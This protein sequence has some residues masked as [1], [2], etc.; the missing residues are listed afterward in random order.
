MPN[1]IP[2]KT[3]GELC[4]ITKIPYGYFQE[5]LSLKKNPYRTFNIRKR[6]SDSKRRI[7]IPDPNLLLIQKSIKRYILSD[8]YV[9]PAATAYTYGSS[10]YLN[11]AYHCNAETI[12]K[13]DIEDFFHSFEERD[14]YNLFLKLGYNKFVSFQLAR[15]CI[16]VDVAEFRKYSNYKA[17]KEKTY[18]YPQLPFGYSYL[19]QGAPTSPILTNLLMSDVDRKIDYI[20]KKHDCNYTR[21]SDDIVL[22]SKTRKS[23]EESISIL[24][25]VK[26]ILSKKFIL[27]SK[28]VKI[29]NKGQRMIVTGL[30]VNNEHP[31]L[32][33]EYKNNLRLQIHY[34]SQNGYA[35]QANRM[36]CDPVSYYNHINGKLLWVKTVEPEFAQKLY[37]KIAKVPK[38]LWVNILY[39]FLLVQHSKPGNRQ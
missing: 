17:S 16:K 38:I 35:E 8:F 15:L 26:D 27:N 4:N 14:I 3:I 34:I 21:Y 1:N 29:I 30:L 13:L 12:I 22:S 39:A 28:K 18:I 7:C 6:N 25:L 23:R 20:S 9:H 10:P 19:P 11:A 5:I 31:Q 24:N 2:I 32:L 36:K 33:K 37:D